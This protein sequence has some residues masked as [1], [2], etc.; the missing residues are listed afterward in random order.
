[1]R[2]SEHGDGQAEREGEFGRHG[3]DGLGLYDA[4]DL[5][6]GSTERLAEDLAHQV[7]APAGATGGGAG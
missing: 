2:K 5:I 6:D 4:A 7:A 3:H 1:M